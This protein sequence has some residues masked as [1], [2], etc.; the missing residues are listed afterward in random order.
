LGPKPDFFAYEDPHIRVRE[1]LFLDDRIL[2]Y[3]QP[4]PDAD[5]EIEEI[6]TTG[7]VVE[8]FFLDVFNRKTGLGA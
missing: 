2:V 1:I 8:G 4:D 3:R 6:A 7:S 5:W